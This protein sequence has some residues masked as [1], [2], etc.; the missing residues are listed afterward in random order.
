[1]SKRKRVPAALHAEISEYSALLRALRTQ[2]TLDL[3]SQLIRARTASQA[4]TDDDLL[5]DDNDSDLDGGESD[6]LQTELPPR[7]VTAVSSSAGDDAPTTLKRKRPPGKRKLKITSTKA[8]DHW[9]RWPLMAGDLHVPEW[10]LEDEIKVLAVHHVR[11][12]LTQPDATPEDGK[13][14]EDLDDDF[15]NTLLP[16]TSLDALSDEAASYLSRILAL[17]ATLKAPAA[18]SMQNRFAPFGWEAVMAAVSSS[19]IADAKF[20]ICSAVQR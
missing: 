13:L 20:V 14:L 12:T 7:S 17:V 4:N 10:T 19:G 1:M 16:Q 3:T 6:K 2:D 8:R 18:E 11:R 9:T 15:A 5:D